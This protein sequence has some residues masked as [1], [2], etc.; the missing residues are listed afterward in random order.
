M[1]L[2]IDSADIK[3]IYECYE[4]GLDGIARANDLRVV[5]DNVMMDRPGK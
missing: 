2:F 1:Q 4:T 3:E 5:P